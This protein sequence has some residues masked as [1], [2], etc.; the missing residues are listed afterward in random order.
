MQQDK[1]NLPEW[2]QA[3]RDAFGLRIKLYDIQNRERP[4][5]MFNQD[6]GRWRGVGAGGGTCMR[7]IRGAPAHVHSPGMVA[8]GTAE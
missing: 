5:S 3:I 6:V 1:A 7:G 4:R 8:S 2:V